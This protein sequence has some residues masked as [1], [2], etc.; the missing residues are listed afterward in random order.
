MPA[1]LRNK[2]E[3]FIE[4]NK[5]I[6]NFASCF[7]RKSFLVGEMRELLWGVMLVALTTSCK[8]IN[9]ENKPVEVHGDSIELLIR[10]DS[11]AGLRDEGE[12]KIPLS[13]DGSFADFIYSF[14]RDAVMQKSRI[15]FPLTCIKSDKKSYINA[16]EWKFDP[17]F[18]HMDTYT[19]IHTIDN[20]TDAEE[21]TSAVTAQLEWILLKERLIKRYSFNRL[22]GFWKL[23]GI[24]YSV[25]NEIDSIVGG[26]EFYHFYSRFANDS[27]FQAA[28]V[29]NPLKFVTF[30]PDDEFRMLETTLEDGQWF[31]FAPLLPSDTLTNVVYG[32]AIPS[33]SNLRI[34]ELKGNGNGFNNAL[35]FKRKNGQWRLIEFD[36]L[37]D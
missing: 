1:N 8:G 35:Y 29:A 33:K 30:D 36:D 10:N 23:Y 32:Q 22:Q 15:D 24:D 21:D 31:A 2:T 17:I 12:D 3:F 13:V 9:K 26:E 37:S 11:I 7:L 4:K 20:D 25:L 6:S 27:V 14:S 16:N 5:R 34:L 18:S 19:I 28:R